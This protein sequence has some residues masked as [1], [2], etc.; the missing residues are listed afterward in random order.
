VFV[1]KQNDWRKRKECSEVK[2]SVQVKRRNSSA[3]FL[4]PVQKNQKPSVAQTAPEGFFIER[5]ARG[6][7]SD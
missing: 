7:I 5:M 2:I 4:K 1:V 3:Q 6:F